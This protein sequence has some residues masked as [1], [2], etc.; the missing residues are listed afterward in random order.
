[1]S[2]CR[3]VIN[4]D[5]VRELIAKGKWDGGE[6][7]TDAWLCLLRR[8][9]ARVVSHSVGD[10]VAGGALLLTDPKKKWDLFEFHFLG[11][12]MFYGNT[13]LSNSSIPPVAKWSIYSC[14]DNNSYEDLQ[15]KTLCN[16]HLLYRWWLCTLLT[17]PNKNS[18]RQ[19]TQTSKANELTKIQ[20]FECPSHQCH[21]CILLSTH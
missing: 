14:F 11:A 4:L 8:G 1:M 9:V 12:D 7:E 19:G 17:R 21:I 6:E 15:T 2:S 5:N 3:L 16:T 20:M 10:K 18:Q 13:I